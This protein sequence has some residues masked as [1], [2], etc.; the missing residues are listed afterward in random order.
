MTWT[1]PPPMASTGTSSARTWC[2]SSPASIPVPT[3]VCEFLLGRYCASTNE[4]EIQEGLQ[5]VE[6]Q[7]RDRAVRS[8]EEELFK[9]RPGDRLGQAD[10]HHLGPPRRQDRLLCGH[11]AQPAAQGRE[12]RRQARPRQRADADGRV[13]RRDRPELRRRDRPGE[14]RQA[15]LGRR[16]CGRSSSRSATCWTRSTRDARSSR[17][18]EWK[19]FLLRSI[20]LEPTAMTERNR[21]VCSCA[22]CRSSRTTTTWSSS[23]RG[24]PARAT[25]SSRSRPTPISSPAARPRWPGCS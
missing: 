7:L 4:E 17:T 5:I 24:A 21:D 19:N 1:V 16:L 20:G 6:R 11:A 13:L 8:G 14:E 22:W 18:A 15:L 3:Y 9:A 10:R 25:S 12:H 23:G 2:G